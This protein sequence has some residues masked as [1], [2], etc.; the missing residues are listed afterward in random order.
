MADPVLSLAA[1]SAAQSASLYTAAG[2]SS[3]TIVY[4]GETSASST[5]SVTPQSTITPSTSS[6]T[7]TTAQE[8]VESG[9][10]GPDYA[11]AYANN[12]TAAN[13]AAQPT[14]GSTG[15]PA[16]TV[17]AAGSTV[18]AFDTVLNPAVVYGGMASVNT[19]SNRI[20]IQGSGSFAEVCNVCL[21]C[22]IFYSCSCCSYPMAPDVLGNTSLLHVS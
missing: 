11:G 21:T 5:P 12:F 16:V 19:A 14:T 18:I 7:A 17:N 20:I 22:V 10:G 3:A 9:G 15:S 2:A 1:V 4:A 6:S 13:V 8:N